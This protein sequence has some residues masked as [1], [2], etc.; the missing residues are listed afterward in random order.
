MN[1]TSIVVRSVVLFV[2]AALAMP[3]VTHGAGLTG[4]AADVPGCDTVSIG[5]QACAV[6]ID[7]DPKPGNCTDQ[8][9]QCTGCGTGTKSI[10]CGST[11]AD[12]GHSDCIGNQT[13]G[14]DSGNTCISGNC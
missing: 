13:Q 9:G 14:Y 12:C 2:S 11:G 8:K 6:K 1:A 5:K 10:K 7:V 4:G 3:L